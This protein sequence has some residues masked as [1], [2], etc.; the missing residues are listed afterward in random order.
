MT[1]EIPVAH[2]L[3][4]LLNPRSIAVIGASDKSSRMGGMPLD[5]LA[6]FR[7]GGNV[8]PVNPKY[9]EAF[10]YRCY[11]DIES[12][13]E[14][15]DV[16]VLAIPAAE[17][18]SMLERCERKGVRAAIV[19]ASG[20]AEAGVT[21]AALQD[22]LEEFTAK[23]AMVV[24][25]PN[26]AGFANLNL[27]AHTSF[28]IKTFKSSPPQTERGRVTLLTQSGNVCATV[29]PLLR[30]LG[31]PVSHFI[32]TGNEA[33][34]EFSEY[35]EFLAQDED[36]ECVVGYLEQLRDGRRFIKVARDFARRDKPLILLKAGD[37]EKGSE[38][39]R[40]HTSALAGNQAL[41]RAAFRQLNV[42]AADDFQQMAD[43]AWL[44][45]FRQR[46]GG[47]RVG[48]VTVSGAVGAIL[49]DKLIGGGL[50]V[51]T[52]P[53]TVQRALRTAVSDY[54]MVTNPVDVTGNIVADIS[55]AQT[56]LSQMATTEAVDTV[57]I[58]APSTVLD[59]MADTLVEVSRAHNRLFVVI[60]TGGATC[61]Q[62]LAVAGIPV[63]SDISRAARALIPYCHWLARRE[64]V[65]RWDLLCGE[66][67][68]EPALESKA[69]VADLN[70]LQAKQLLAG[71]GVTPVPEKAA[72][73][74]TAAVA[75]AETLGYPVVLK[76]LSPDIP[77]K[78]E[79]GG[80]ALNLA[81]E[82]A[83][84]NSYREV[85]ER[86]RKQAPRARLQGV[87]V[88]KM[89]K[90]IAELIVGT[91]RDP[92]FGATLT[93]GLGGVLTEIY[94]D[95]S[96]R[97]L[98][99]DAEI[100]RE[101]LHELK[102]FVLLDGFRG[103]EKADVDAACIA[104]AGMSRAAMQLGSAVQEMEVNPLQLKAGTGGV[105]ALDAL[106]LPPEAAATPHP[107]D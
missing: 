33:D 102:S 56:V 84:R 6:H 89:S 7:F 90:G 37:S 106:I 96:H 55:S 4:P 73:D 18:T 19:Y 61:H 44:T 1:K 95:V 20:F 91:T 79:I 65:K 17:V 59:R 26:C 3:D 46:A 81:D 105:A 30:E 57:V 21:G 23:S 13:P 53:E 58:Y 15:P 69:Q 25:G 8:Y 36:T 75:A 92:V 64:S 66:E 5:L 85:T 28:A 80:V 54:G 107:G 29:F 63:F 39:V 60:D 48:I 68:A 22:R 32:N 87:L 82:S 67:A 100:A 16:V 45:Q 34:L 50:E 31:V 104:I 72:A 86:A 78:T 52:L 11:P 77:H 74:E 99:I 10:G 40:S 35:L 83:V 14:S 93:V 43:L 24:A 2:Q 76:V 103:K 98:P 51:P 101:M 62:R 94:K 41:Y 9:E 42:M 71:F 88:Q 97:V 27:N 49:A 12:L 38:A 47:P 70:E